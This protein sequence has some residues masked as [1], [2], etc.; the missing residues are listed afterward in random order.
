M[1]VQL[2]TRSRGETS[3]AVL[4]CMNYGLPTIVNANGS[5][6]DLADDAV[7][8]LTDEFS[9]EALVE[10]ID[11]LWSD[12]HRRTKIGKRARE[13]ILDHHAPRSCADQYFVAIENFHKKTAAGIGLLTQA[14]ANVEPAPD[15]QEELRSLAKTI[16]QSISP[17]ITQRQLLVDV[18]ALVRDDTMQETGDM[19]SEWLRNPPKGLRIEPVYIT[20][21]HGYRYARRFTLGFLNCPTDALNDEPVEY[22]PSDVFL[23]LACNFDVVGKQG[24][25]YQLMKNGGVRVEFNIRVND[26]NDLMM[27]QQHWLTTVVE[28]SGLI[29]NNKSVANTVSDWI[30]KYQPE[31]VNALNHYIHESNND[32]GDVYGNNILNYLIDLDVKV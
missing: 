11:G 21:D 22:A 31:K 4:D 32:H 26:L 2:R 7:W 30:N 9:N 1:G 25:F 16:A 18:S 17:A 8:K 29:Y 12:R 10:A 20:P 15:N 6:S 14:I 24:Q 23:G 28:C 3:A 19:L 13:I 27:N 5:M